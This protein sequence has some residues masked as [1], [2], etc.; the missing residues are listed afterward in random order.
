MQ[1]RYEFTGFEKQVYGRTVKQIK[2][3]VNI[4]H[5]NVKVGD[6]GGFIQEES[7]FPHNSEGWIFQN[8]TVMR[9]GVMWGGEM[10]GGEMWGG[11]MW[12]G[13]M[14]GGVMWGGEMRGGEMRGGE[15]WGGEMHGGEMRGDITKD[16]IYIA[17]LYWPVTVCDTIMTIGCQSHPIEE[18][19]AFTKKQIGDMDSNAHNFWST[20]KDVIFTLI[21]NRK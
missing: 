3:L 12:G 8:A 11:E 4:D 9:G 19:R 5:L 2:S 18:W 10:W 16:P 13:V 20:Y 7:N 15:M 21:D 14:W 6:V 1:K 17:G